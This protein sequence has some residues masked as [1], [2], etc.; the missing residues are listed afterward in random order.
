MH[1]FNHADFLHSAA[2]AAASEASSGGGGAGMDRNGLD[3]ESPIHKKVAIYY[4]GWAKK[5]APGLVN[6]VPAVVYKLP[7]LPQ[8]G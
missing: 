1:G 2:V 8:L 5:Q 7:P 4:R 6:F 3:G